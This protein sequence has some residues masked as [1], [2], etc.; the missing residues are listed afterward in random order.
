MKNS[1]PQ[2][3]IG[4]NPPTSFSRKTLCGILNKYQDN[5]EKFTNIHKPSI[6]TDSNC[7]NYLDLFGDQILN[8][9]VCCKTIL[10][11]PFNLLQ[12]FIVPSDRPIP[13]QVKD[14]G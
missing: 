5:N 13:R 12:S 14:L 10:Y 4:K 9:S 7:D 6:W 8:L 11:F 2:K 1:S 3:H